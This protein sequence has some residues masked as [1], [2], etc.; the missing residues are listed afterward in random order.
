MKVIF[1]NTT[2]KFE[3]GKSWEER[4]TKFEFDVKAGVGLG[5]Y[6]SGTDKVVINQGQVGI[7]KTV[8]FK[9]VAEEGM[10][11]TKT[12]S[13][14]GAVWNYNFKNTGNGNTFQ[15]VEGLTIPFKDGEMY[16]TPSRIPSYAGDTVSVLY[17]PGE[18]VVKDG[19][20]T[21]YIDFDYQG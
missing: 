1:K 12:S 17:I 5:L 15:N 20:V 7:G 10:L 11:A 14:T 19:K 2:L 18:V 8:A 21:L 4:A 3:K 9:L 6:G 16:I 13:E